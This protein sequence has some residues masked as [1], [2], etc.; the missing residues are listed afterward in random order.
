MSL[1]QEFKAIMTGY[2]LSNEKDEVL[3]LMEQ[4]LL[5]SI[6]SAG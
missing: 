6:P 5:E 3:A 1:E 4:L 2:G